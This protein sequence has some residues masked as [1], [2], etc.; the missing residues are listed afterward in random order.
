[1]ATPDSLD[2]FERM[3]E[4]A[5]MKRNR[6]VL[7]RELGLLKTKRDEIR[8][9]PEEG[10]N[11][12]ESAIMMGGYVGMVDEMVLRLIT[13]AD[14]DKALRETNRRQM[15]FQFGLVDRELGIKGLDRTTAQRDQIEQ[16]LGEV[17]DDELDRAIE[18]ERIRT[19]AIFKEEKDAHPDMHKE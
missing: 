8:A 17:S 16:A 12:L 15:K 6:E 7:I 5:R 14:I 4:E 11:D 2:A 19:E 13:E 18:A 3:A 10:R 1:M 9:K